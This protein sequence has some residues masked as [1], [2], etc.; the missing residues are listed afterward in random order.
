MKCYRECTAVW[1]LGGGWCVWWGH[2][3]DEEE[4]QEEADGAEAEQ[5]QLPSVSSSEHGG[6]HVRDRGHQA[7]QTHK[8]IQKNKS[9]EAR[10]M[11]ITEEECKMSTTNMALHYI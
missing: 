4:A 8:L 7:L 6:E 5:Q 9:N 11:S 1:L 3:C 2:L 10:F